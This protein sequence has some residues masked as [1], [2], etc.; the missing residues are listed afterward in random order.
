MRCILLFDT[1]LL[2]TIGKA[3][4]VFRA[5]KSPKLMKNSPSWYFT[6]L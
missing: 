3:D 1:S 6:S 4:F 2:Q 5:S